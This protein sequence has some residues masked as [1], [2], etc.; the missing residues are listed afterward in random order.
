M[1]SLFGVRFVV[2][3]QDTPK[4]AGS[5]ILTSAGGLDAIFDSIVRFPECIECNLGSVGSARDVVIWSVG[6][7]NG[8]T[9][10]FLLAAI[11]A[12]SGL[13]MLAK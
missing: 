2:T 5:D 7:L 13:R 9:V 10:A 8:K 3:A 4:E 1:I 6:V 12:I 11:D